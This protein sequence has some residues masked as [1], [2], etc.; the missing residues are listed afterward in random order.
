MFVGRWHLQSLPGSTTTTSAGTV[1]TLITRSETVGCSSRRWS[2][3]GWAI[4]ADTTTDCS[5]NWSAT[6]NTTTTLLQ[7]PYCAGEAS[8]TESRYVEAEEHC[9]WK[10]S[11]WGNDQWQ[12]MFI[13]WFHP[14]LAFLFAERRPLSVAQT[15]TL[16]WNV[17]LGWADETRGWRWHRMDVSCL[18]R[19]IRTRRQKVSLGSVRCLPGVVALWVRWIKRKPRTDYFCFKCKWMFKKN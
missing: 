13:P 12:T 17:C 18:R 10:R 5:T 19:Y 9:G 14:E 15:W 1:T 16:L 2:H 6:E 11:C 4:T 7:A 8:R 3:A